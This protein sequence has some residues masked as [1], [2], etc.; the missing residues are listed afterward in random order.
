[1]KE[2]EC[3]GVISRTVVKAPV[4]V[5][6]NQTLHYSKRFSGHAAFKK[7]PCL[8][9]KFYIRHVYKLGQNTDVY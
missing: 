3:M 2:T 9:T 8:L 7:M 4:S 6:S 1:M 5:A